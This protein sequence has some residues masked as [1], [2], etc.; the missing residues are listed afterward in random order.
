M[1]VREHFG[2]QFSFITFGWLA[3]GTRN[4]LT[5]GILLAESMEYRWPEKRW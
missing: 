1:F 4:V 3:M 5:I 2:K